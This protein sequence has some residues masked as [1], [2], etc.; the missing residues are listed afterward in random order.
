MHLWAQILSHKPASFTNSMR[1]PACIRITTEND[2][3]F[4]LFSVVP[5]IFG[6]YKAVRFFVVVKLKYNINITTQ[7]KKNQIK[8][9]LQSKKH[10]SD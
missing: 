3:D 4:I 8:N 1:V 5:I 10:L 7:F 2:R 6:Q 9:K